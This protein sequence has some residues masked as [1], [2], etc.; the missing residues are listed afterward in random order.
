MIYNP[1]YFTQF[2]EELYFLAQNSPSEPDA[3]LYSINASDEINLV[4]E[5]ANWNGDKALLS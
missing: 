5:N 4:E 3:D 2:G 1:D